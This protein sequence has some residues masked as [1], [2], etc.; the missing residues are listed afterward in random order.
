[1]I[2]LYIYNILLDVKNDSV[3]LIS[4]KFSGCTPHGCQ[5]LPCDNER[6]IPCLNPGLKGSAGYPPFLAGVV[7]PD[8]KPKI[9]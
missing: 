4:T 6:H 7:V 3:T 2:H 9:P 5:K 8:F 1:M